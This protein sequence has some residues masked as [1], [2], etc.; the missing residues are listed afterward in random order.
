VVR[1]GRAAVARG[2]AVARGAGDRLRQAT[3]VPGD[4]LGDPNVRLAVHVALT[5]RHV[6]SMQAAGGRADRA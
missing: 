4:D 5:L 2:G 1:R 3:D 6:L